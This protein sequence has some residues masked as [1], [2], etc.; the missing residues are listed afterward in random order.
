M[1]LPLIKVP[2]GYFAIGMY[3]PKKESNV[4]TMWRSAHAMGAAFLFTIGRRYK[5]EASDTTKAWRHTPLWHYTDIDSFTV[6]YECPLIGV[7]L[8]DDAA[9]L[10]SFR[11]PDRAVY[12]LG[13]EDHGLPPE[14]MGRCQAL[15]QIPGRYCLNVAVAGSIVM[16]DRQ[17]KS[18]RVAV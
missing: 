6:P 7:E 12:L 3:H 10:P 2:R 5:P 18:I 14:V 17:A 4:G 8:S 15:I 1:T 9:N 13:A 11:H 16:Y